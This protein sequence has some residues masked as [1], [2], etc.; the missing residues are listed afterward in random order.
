VEP[1][2]STFIGARL[3]HLRQKV[4]IKKQTHSEKSRGSSCFLST[5]RLAP[6]GGDDNRNSASDPLRA[7]FF[8]HSSAETTTTLGF[9][10]R[11]IVWGASCA[12]HDLRK[13]CLRA[14]DRPVRIIMRWCAASP[15]TILTTMTIVRHGFSCK[16]L[17][18]RGGGINA[19]MP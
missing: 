1:L 2:E 16:C 8:C 5:S 14:S 17:N 7:V 3:C 19:R 6:R 10:L 11:V 15:I 4:R 12:L 9:P 13:L 18:R